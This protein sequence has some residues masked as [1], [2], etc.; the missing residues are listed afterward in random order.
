MC[1]CHS[2]WGDSEVIVMICMQMFP[3]NPTY[4]I[5]KGEITQGMAVTRDPV[6]SGLGLNTSGSGV[7]FHPPLPFLCNVA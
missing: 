7:P 4:V 5:L 6:D 3:E 2:Q 1:S